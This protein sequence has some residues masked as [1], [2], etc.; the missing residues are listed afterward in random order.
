MH[1]I[2]DRRLISEKSTADDDKKSKKDHIKLHVVGEFRASSR[3][4]LSN[5]TNEFQP[6]SE[7]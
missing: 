7:G 1:E 3:S 4:E 2:D 5:V 6:T